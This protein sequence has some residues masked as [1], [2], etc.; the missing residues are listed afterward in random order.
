MAF[1]VGGLGLNSDS[2]NVDILALEVE[3]AGLISARLHKAHCCTLN[4]HSDGI[5][6]TRGG[7]E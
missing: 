4:P 6:M 5:N 7:G 2:I 1:Q 3:A